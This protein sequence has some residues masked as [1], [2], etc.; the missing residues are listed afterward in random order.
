MPERRF[1]EEEARRIFASVAERQRIETP[2]T[3]G[4]TLAEMQDVARASGL[5]P[6]LVAA[7]AAE[8]SAGAPAEIPNFLGAPLA[9]R[10]RRVLPVAVDDDAWARV[11][12]ELRREFDTPGVPT[13]MGRQREWSL[14]AAR[15]TRPFTSRSC[16]AR[17]EPSS[18]WSRP[19]RSRARARVGSCQGASSLW[20]SGSVLQP[21]GAAGP[22]VWFLPVLVAS[23]SPS[24]L[25]GALGD[26][27]HV[28][29]PHRAA[30]RASAGPR[31]TGRARG[32][33]CLWRA[34]GAPRARGTT[35]SARSRR[36]PRSLARGLW[37]PR[38][39]G[40]AFVASGFLPFTPCRAPTP[41]ARSRRSSSAPS[42]ARRKPGAARDRPG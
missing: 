3:D 11:V 31:G 9:V 42:C 7:V 41:S 28:G 21:A 29:R 14:G 12:T 36:A 17:P 27:A 4:L 39:A 26:V 22:E 35:A 19:S 33:P 38:P 2:A 23:S 10:Q 16:R 6:A 34:A 32:R 13:E 1:T 18:R 30:V 40:R 5:D 8:M 37:R 15:A 20:C 24:S 25:M